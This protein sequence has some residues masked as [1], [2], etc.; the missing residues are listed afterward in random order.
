[1]SPYFVPLN[2]IPVALGAPPIETQMYQEQ[3][4]LIPK[5]KKIYLEN[6]LLHT[7]CYQCPEGRPA[8]LSW[9]ALEDHHNTRH[10]KDPKH[11]CDYEGCNKVFGNRQSLKKTSKI[12][13]S[14]R[15]YSYQMHF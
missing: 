6:N 7:K 14:Q 1:M 15:E 8:F 11:S 9:S 12:T 13:S 3:Q 2:E 10:S 4:A 5:L